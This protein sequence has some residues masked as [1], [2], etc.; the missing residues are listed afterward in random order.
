MVLQQV[1]QDGFD[2]YHK[3][4]PLG[5]GCYESGRNHWDLVRSASLQNG[6]AVRVELTDSV[7]CAITSNGPVYSSIATTYYGWKAGD[8]EAYR[9]VA[10]QYIIVARVLHRNF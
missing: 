8:E 9:T 3:M 1:G 10:S 4:Q 2:S 6:A 7:S 5:D